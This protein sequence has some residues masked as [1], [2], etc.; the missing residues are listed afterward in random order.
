MLTLERALALALESN[1]DLKSAHLEAA[2]AEDRM[3]AARTKRFPALQWAALGMQL[4]VPLYF[5]FPANAFGPSIPA[6]DT[7][8]RAPLQPGALLIGSLVQPLSQQYKIGLSLDVL[9]ADRD[10]A[11]EPARGR[12]QSVVAEVKRVYYSILQTQSALETVE[13]SIQLYRELDRLTGD[14]VLRQVALKSDNL[15]AKARLANAEYEALK[16]RGPLDTQKEQL[17][18]LLGRDITTPF[19]VTAL[20]QRS[21]AETDLEAARRLAQERRPEVRE[22]ELKL[23]HAIADRRVKKAE[24]YPDLGLSLSYFSPINYASMI[25]ANVTTVGLQFTWEPF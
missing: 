14:Y 8:I 16:L 3:A 18:N 5:T 1:R 17:N 6:T 4:L 24:F 11:V 13:Q 10:L 2:K 12:R 7:S 22:A 19:Q 23:R 21:W 15:E 9:K 25:P 20:E